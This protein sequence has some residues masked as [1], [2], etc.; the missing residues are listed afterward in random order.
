MNQSSGEIV[1]YKGPEGISLDVRLEDES[2][3]LDAHQMARLFGRDRTVIVRHVR[4]IYKTNELDPIATCAKNAQ[5]AADGK[6]SGD[7][8]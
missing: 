2:V 5:V 3:W 4:N 7:R 6:R 8:S 1:I